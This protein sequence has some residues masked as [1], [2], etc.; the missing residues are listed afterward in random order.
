MSDNKELSD[1]GGPSEATSG[2]MRLSKPDGPI[3][4]TVKRAYELGKSDGAEEE[5]AEIEHMILDRAGVEGREE[6]RVELTLLAYLVK[7]RG[8]P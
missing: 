3:L 4:E 7:R 2:P 5:R 1:S 6:V 8:T